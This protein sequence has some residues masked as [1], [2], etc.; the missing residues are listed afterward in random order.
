MKD[1][2]TITHD[3]FSIKI[4][5]KTLYADLGAERLISA[6]KN[7]QKIVVE[8][9]SFVGHSETYDLQ[10]ALG[11]YIMYKEILQEQHSERLL[12]MAVNDITYQSIFSTEI[13]Q[14]LLAKQ[15]LR[16][17]IFDEHNEVITQWIN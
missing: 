9:K 4:G 5:R 12:Y 15:P 16:L 1:G 17:I 8:I 13:G 11:Q 7:L 3:Q 2:W 10:Q 14:L 6:K